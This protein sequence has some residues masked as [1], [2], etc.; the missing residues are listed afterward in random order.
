[1]KQWPMVNKLFH[2]RR[3]VTDSITHYWESIPL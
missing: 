3:A 1:V 2:R